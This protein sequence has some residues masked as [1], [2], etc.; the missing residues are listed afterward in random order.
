MMYS[1]NGF[2]GFKLFKYVMIFLIALFFDVMIL[3]LIFNRDAI[4]EAFEEAFDSGSTYEENETYYDE[5]EEESEV[6]K[7]SVSYYLEDI[8]YDL[9]LSLSDLNTVNNYFNMGLN[10][11]VYNIPI[12]VKHYDYK[13]TTCDGTE[14]YLDN[15]SSYMDTDN[16]EN[17]RYYI[18]TYKTRLFAIL[19]GALSNEV[20]ISLEESGTNR[21][22]VLSMNDEVKII[23]IWNDVNKYNYVY[24]VPVINGNYKLVIG[25]SVIYFDSYDSTYVK[26]YN[27]VIYVGPELGNVLR[28][29]IR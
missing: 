29:Y 14:Y 21:N 12:D 17:R 9:E 8:E 1:N 7:L 18:G 5:T 26:Y 22:I 25:N 24:D 28:T 19:N 6:C 20:S 13:I 27:N 16:D 11:E 15:N 4:S 10:R 3:G 2:V 23:N